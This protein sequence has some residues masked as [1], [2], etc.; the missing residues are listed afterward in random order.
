[1]ACGGGTPATRTPIDGD[2]AF[3][4]VSVVAM[5]SH[6]VLADQTVIIHGDRIAAIGPSSDVVPARHARIIDGHGAYLVPA[7]A[8]M[9]GHVGDLP[10]LTM[11]A[12]NGVTSVRNMWGSREVLAWQQAIAKGELFGP[13]IYSAGP[14]MDGVPPR[15]GGCIAVDNPAAAARAVEAQKAHGY[16]FIKVLGD[17][18]V[19]V[20]D[21]IVARARELGMP[22]IGHVPYAVGLEHALA[23]GQRSIEHLT[24]YM[25]GAQRDDSKLKNERGTLARQYQA[26]FIDDAKLSALVGR[27]G[28]AGVWNTPTLVTISKFGPPE[29]SEVL[30][31]RPEMRFV[32][33]LIR[34]TWDPSKDFRTK[35]A[36][37]ADWA[38]MRRA[39][40]MRARIVRDLNAAGAHIVAGTDFENPFVVP[41]WSLYEELDLLVAAGLSPYEALRA[42]TK[43]AS[44]LVVGDFGVIAVGKRADLILV[45]GNPLTDL[46]HL[47]QRRGVMI[48]GAWYADSEL[49]ARLDKLVHMFDEGDRLASVPAVAG[50]RT[51]VARAGSTFA[52]NERLAREPHAIEAASAYDE[53]SPG[54]MLTVARQELDDHAAV[55]SLTLRRT[56]TNGA[57]SAQLAVSGGRLRGHAHVDPH[58][59]LDVDEPASAAPFVTTPLGTW[60]TAVDRARSLAVG[61]SLVVTLQDFEIEPELHVVEV[62][63]TVKRLDDRR[64]SIDEKRYNGDSHAEVTV[65]SDGSIISARGD[66]SIAT[67]DLVAR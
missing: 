44:D 6:A 24:G 3:V 40:A 15:F 61:G 49:R 43:E 18:H 23:A 4:H 7:L 29:Q 46:H 42:G 60:Q 65:S 10:T 2:V 21:A 28:G 39:D 63:E 20:Y 37:A 13:T 36:T 34:S 16:Q 48:R 5:D 25:E 52:G 11:L 35:G 26:D 62:R 50:S 58:D 66:V 31:K 30:A 1:M 53:T 22:V 56:S 55:R 9:H 45:E 17:L 38:A 64:F 14:I 57:L 19:D 51:F 54:S 32:S 59:E 41:G 8:D 27:T 33:P 47:A 67:V 12:A